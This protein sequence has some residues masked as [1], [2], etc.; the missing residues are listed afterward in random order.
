MIGAVLLKELVDNLRDRR[1]VL[2]A[3]IYPLIGPLA[4]GLT[5]ALVAEWQRT[6]LPLELP[7]VGAERA[8]SLIAF[9]EQN[10]ALLQPAPADPE[11]AV[12]EGKARAVLIIPEDYPADFRAGRPATLQLVVDESSNRARMTIQRAQR[13]LTAWGGQ[14]AA[15][16][17]LARGVSPELAN[18]VLVD[19]VDV[20][21]PEKLA[22]NLLN[23]LPLFLLLASFIGGMHVAIDATAGERERGSLEPLLINPISRGA[24][25][26]GKWG[27]TLVFSAAV[28]ALTL[29]GFATMVRFVP[30]EAIGLQLH[31]GPREAGAILAAALPLTLL[32]GALQLLVATF[33]RSFKEAQTYLSLLLFA[34]MIPGMLLGLMPIQPQPW[35]MFVPGL[36]QQMLVTGLVSG[37]PAA[38]WALVASAATTAIASAALLG[39]TA[40]LFTRESIVFGR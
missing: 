17:L 22:A 9:L 39:V 36:S 18:P 14:V 33:A 11:A 8:P 15:L 37:E 19:R 35:M 32:A 6:D 23:M 10:G 1:S 3:L 5:L 12:R 24:L 16:R 7:V 38:G 34:P 28:L 40:R 20:A 25:V 26:A 13:L 4:L 31:I 2:S 29:A 21:T 30:L 27:A